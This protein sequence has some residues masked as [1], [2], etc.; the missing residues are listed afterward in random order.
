MSATASGESWS[1]RPS[2]ALARRSAARSAAEIGL[3]SSTRAGEPGTQRVGVVGHDCERFEQRAVAVGKVAGCGQRRRTRDEKLDSVLR[4]RVAGSRRSA[5]ANQCAALAGASR[6]A[7]SPASRSTATAS[8]RR[9]APS[10]GRGERARPPSHRAPRAPARTARGHPA[11]NRWASPRRPRGARGGVESGN[12]GARRCREPDRVA[13]ARRLRPS[14]RPRMSRR[15]PPPARARTD[16]PLPP[17]PP[18]RGVPRRT[19]RRVLRSARRRRRMAPRRPSPRPRQGARRYRRGRATAR[20][21]RDRRGCR[22]SPRRGRSRR[23]GRPFRREVRELRRASA[24]RARCCQL[25]RALCALE[26]G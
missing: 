23:R 10:A 7:S 18:A 22:R 5:S 2:R 4:G 24:R 16:R 1:G 14:P 11:A 3:D 25:P 6:A 8:S 9:R 26:R 13:P 21:A 20:A 15:R 12:G 17:L 19:A